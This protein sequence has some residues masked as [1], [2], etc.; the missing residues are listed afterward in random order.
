MQFTLTRTVSMSGTQ[1]DSDLEILKF[2][3]SFPK[4]NFFEEPIVL[5]GI[6]GD[7]SQCKC[8]GAMGLQL[9]IF[10]VLHFHQCSGSQSL[11]F[12]LCASQAA[13]IIGSLHQQSTILCGVSLA[14]F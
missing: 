1:T 13:A 4:C 10:E 6:A 14:S 8:N 12:S 11:K 2:C 7:L 9:I 3:L 5:D